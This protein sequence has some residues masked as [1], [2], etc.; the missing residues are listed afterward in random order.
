MTI[1]GRIST[2]INRPIQ[3]VWSYLDNEANDPVWRRPY[4]KQV[5]RVGTGPSKQGTRF[6]GILRNGPYLSDVTH[7]EPPVCM[8]WKF[9]SYPAGPLKE[10]EGTYLL[11]PEGQGTRMTLKVTADTFGLLGI[12]MSFPMSILLRTIL[13]PQLLK[14]LKQGVEGQATASSST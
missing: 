9:V 2:V 1:Q 5:T 4:A 12:V 8:S 11:S 14:Q 13:G 3:E 7:Y 6:Q 10:R